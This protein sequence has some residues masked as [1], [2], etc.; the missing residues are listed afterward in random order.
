LKYEKTTTLLEIRKWEKRLMEKDNY[1]DCTEEEID[2]I[3]NQDRDLT[4]KIEIYNNLWNIKSR[5]FQNLYQKGKVRSKEDEQQFKKIIDEVVH[6][7]SETNMT[8]ENQYL[9]NHLYSAYYYGTGDFESC[10]KHLLENIDLIHSKPHIFEEEPN[11]YLSVLTNAIFLATK[12]GKRKDAYKYLDSLKQLES[13]APESNTEDRDMRLFAISKSTELTLCIQAG[14]FEK[15]IELIP[16]IE[17]GLVKYESK[18]SSVRKASLYLNIAVLHFGKED[19]N[20]ALKW[21]NQL[22][23]NISIDT[24]QDIHCMAQLLNLVIHLELGNKSLLPYALR[25]TQ[26]YLQTR[27]KV[28]QFESI[29]LSFVNEILKK[30]SDKTTP[31]LYEQLASNLRPLKDDPFELNAFDYFDFLSW[32]ESKMSH[33]NVA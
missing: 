7:N 6:E 22:L 19:Y 29:F 18:L 11:V 4:K 1:E 12:L 3:L 33:K 9:L 10:Y 21:T 5:I 15:G 30:R 13:E 28:Y 17:E 24:T 14:D 16:S 32:A 2:K 26:R 25:S 8:S 23:N 31:E 20:E 27:N